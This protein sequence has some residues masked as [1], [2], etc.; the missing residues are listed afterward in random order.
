MLVAASTSSTTLA[1]NLSRASKAYA[2]SEQLAGPTHQ[3][4]D[5]RV[6]DTRTRAKGAQ[7]C[8]FPDQRH[9]LLRDSKAQRWRALIQAD[10]VHLAFRKQSQA[11]LKR[12]LVSQRD[13]AILGQNRDVQVAS[14]T[15]G[16]ACRGA[17]EES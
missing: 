6:L 8:G 9:S 4:R 3:R 17:E 12:K 7:R 5:L 1:A 14:F 11:R 16:A 15:V 10:Q 2:L 13:I